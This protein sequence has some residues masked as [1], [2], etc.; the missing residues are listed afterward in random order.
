MRLHFIFIF[1]IF[2]FDIIE[3]KVNIVQLVEPN[4]WILA[5]VFDPARVP[6]IG[7]FILDFLFSL[8]N[9]VLIDKFH[10]YFMCIFVALSHQ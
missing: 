5:C 7:D 3:L 8:S 4:V 10:P 2:I 1:I 9:F 6:Q